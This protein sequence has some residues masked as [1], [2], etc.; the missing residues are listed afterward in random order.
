[1]EISSLFPIP[2]CKVSL[3][4]ALTAEEL[5]FFEALP[6]RPN[7]GN[8]I[9][10]DGYVLRNPFLSSIRSFIEESLREY[11][12]GVYQPK[13]EVQLPITQSW[14][15]LT[16]DNGFHHKHQHPNSLVSGVFYIKTCHGR[17]KI[18]FFKDNYQQIKIDPM[19]FNAYNSTSWW[20]PV[21]TGDL[22]LFPSELP[23][24]VD[25]IQG[26]DRM[27]L[28][29]NTFPVGVMGSVMGSDQLCI[30]EAT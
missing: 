7:M 16:K 2:V 3:G 5:T 28:S 23:H 10:E 19:V 1:V 29:F 11:F 24:C 22:L 25:N 26:E 12:L 30:K 20:L 13:D 14:V 9:S 27:S 17:D 4:R 8:V 6:M 15:N 18:R 21:E